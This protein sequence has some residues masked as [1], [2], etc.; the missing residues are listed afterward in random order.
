M[1]AF[2]DGRSKLFM[3]YVESKGVSSNS[4]SNLDETA[5][6][7]LVNRIIGFF[8]DNKFH[9][10]PE[11]FNRITSKIIISYPLQEAVNNLN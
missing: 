11:D 4:P 8:I 6:K 5:K 7:F 9:M 3:D 1:N 2:N 10:R